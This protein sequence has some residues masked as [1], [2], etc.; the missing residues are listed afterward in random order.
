MVEKKA[1]WHC[2]LPKLLN[3]LTWAGEKFQDVFYSTLPLE[4]R[5]GEYAAT[6]VMALQA[7]CFLTIKITEWVIQL[8]LCREYLSAEPS[9]KVKGCTKPVPQVRMGKAYLSL[10]FSPLSSAHFC[11]LGTGAAPGNLFVTTNKHQI[12]IITI[13]IIIILQGRNGKLKQLRAASLKVHFLRAS[14]AV[15]PLRWLIP[16]VCHRV[17]VQW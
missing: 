4:S 9:V 13:I 7:L 12:M 10:F 6:K 2:T 14:L 8:C 15:L 5:D 3:I 17:F 11:S 1:R 16:P